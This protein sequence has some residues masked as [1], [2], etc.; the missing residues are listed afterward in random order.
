MTKHMD[1]ASSKANVLSF[2]E[3]RILVQKAKTR[4]PKKKIDL[5]KSDDFKKVDARWK[6][7]FQNNKS[8]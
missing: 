6:K 1:L 8:R 2:K 5:E 4:G 3:K 7:M